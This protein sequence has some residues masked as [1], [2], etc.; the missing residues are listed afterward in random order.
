[1]KRDQQKAEASLSLSL[2]TLHP[3]NLIKREKK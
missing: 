2:S 1:M 3:F